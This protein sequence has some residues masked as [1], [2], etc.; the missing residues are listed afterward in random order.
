MW[1]ELASH[2]PEDGALAVL[3]SRLAVC[4]GC[5]YLNGN[6]CGDCG[7][8]ANRWTIWRGKLLNGSCS[9]FTFTSIQKGT[10]QMSETKT[11]PTEPGLYWAR[12][13]PPAISAGGGLGMPISPGAPGYAGRPVDAAAPRPLSAMPQVVPER[14]ASDDYNAVV[15]LYGTVP[16]LDLTVFLFG[17]LG[18]LNRQNRQWQPQGTEV[19]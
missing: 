13:H 19:A 7:S 10:L 16:F 18:G 11:Y 5:G 3:E 12:V 9:Y 4:N 14:V 1:E 8:C 2:W 17:N 15:E 6:G